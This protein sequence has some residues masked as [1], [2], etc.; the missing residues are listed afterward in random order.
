MN[1][2]GRAVLCILSVVFLG[3]HGTANA[4]DPAGNPVTR[5][6]HS[7]SERV[8]DL[9]FVPA[10]PA[11]DA[12]SATHLAI[13]PDLGFDGFIGPEGVEIR[14]Q[15]GEWGVAL[16]LV[17]IG[18]GE[19]LGLVAPAGVTAEGPRADLR[20]GALTEWF[21]N[22]DRGLEHGF[23]IEER[24]AGAGNLVLELML[25][26]D[27]LPQLMEDRSGI[28]F[29]RPGLPLPLMSY[30]GLVV[31]DADRRPLNARM[32]LTPRAE[33]RSLRIVVDD[34]GA[35]YPITIDPLLTTESWTSDESDYTL[36]VAWG[37][38]DGDGDLDL[39]VG[40]SG[41]PNR[42][43]LNSGNVL[44][45]S[46][47]WSSSESDATKSIAWGDW[48]SDGDL[49]LVTGNT[50][51]PNRVY[52]NLGGSLET[53]RLFGAPSESDP[54]ESVAW[55]DWDGDGDLGARSRQLLQPE[56]CVSPTPAAHCK[57]TSSPGAPLKATPTRS[58]AWGD[59]G[60]RRD[61]DLAAGN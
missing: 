28:S 14:S 21:L 43:Y 34:I 56:S 32:D 25:E 55:G 45:T 36:S 30:R 53:T 59:C 40:N 38:W 51:E 6:L 8:P 16:E 24:P 17:R 13:R 37:D 9:A 54:T 3:T 57:L 61:L 2:A 42:V 22:H 12:G 20:R 58:M 18:R 11:H 44:Q 39:A 35:S 41:Q 26:S 46:A 10:T 29:L 1:S 33:G 23:T 48:D 27:L 31:T 4:P 7:A 49:D 60:R 52:V 19:Q 50:N 47:S 5:D 15:D